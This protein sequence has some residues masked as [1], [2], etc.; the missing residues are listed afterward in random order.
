MA[1]VTF[2]SPGCIA[3]IVLNDPP[4]N[5]ISRSVMADINRYIDEELRPKIKLCSL[6][7]TSDGPN[8]SSGMDIEDIAG[9]GP[10]EAT[11]LSRICHRVMRGLEELPVPVIA[12]ISGRAYDIGF[13]LALA[14]DIRI[15]TED[16]VFGMPSVRLG[17]PP[18]SGATS[19]LPGIIGA[20]RAREILYTG[21]KVTA[22]EAHEIG[23]VSRVVSGK[24]A[25]MEDVRA[26]AFRIANNAPD[27]VR[28]TKALINLAGYGGGDEMDERE[29]S[30]F[31]ESF[32]PGTEQRAGM[33]ARLEGQRMPWGKSDVKWCS[34]LEGADK[35]EGEQG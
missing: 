15:C 17:A 26:T 19:R 28:Q 2:T 25:L 16:A 1:Y 13:E 23:L 34:S 6:V 22:R 30:A 10:K 14:C 33:M 35:E 27:A 29:A 3:A 11:L 12:A 32:G 31:G 5:Y 18:S 24:A 8:F 9:L 21:R 20:G 4:D 7:V